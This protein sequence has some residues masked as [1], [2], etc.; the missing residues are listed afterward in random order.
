[1]PA[2]DIQK[3]ANHLLEDITQVSLEELELRT[4]GLKDALVRMKITADEA[5]R[6][7]RVAVRVY[8]GL[9]KE[10]KRRIKESHVP[11]PLSTGR[12]LL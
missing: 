5:L 2:D 10:R 8:D 3:A 9:R 4:A 1:M 11:V 12:I 6:T 7:Y